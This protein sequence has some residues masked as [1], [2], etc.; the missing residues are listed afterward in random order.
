MAVPAI[1]PFANKYIDLSD[2]ET[3][4]FKALL[5]SM[6][7]FLEVPKRKRVSQERSRGRSLIEPAVFESYKHWDNPWA[8]AN[9]GLREGMKVL[10][11]GSGRGMLQFY[12]SSK[13]M[14]VFSVDISH[15]RSKLFKRIG[16]LLGKIG[17]DYSIDPYIVHR[18]LNRTY[19]TNVTFRHESAA[20]MSF[21]DAYFDR[22][23]CISVIEHM[24]D[25]TIAGSMREMERV[26]KPGGLLLLTFDFHP[27][28]NPS[29]IGFT[30]E[31]FRRKVL[32]ASGLRIVG[33]EPDFRVDGWESYLRSINAF[34]RK[35]NPNTSFGVVL[36][37]D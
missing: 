15:N 6:N 9:A 24:D 4:E 32:A 29:I 16:E 35:N 12:L 3:I 21:P 19:K 28:P 17:I 26:L 8:V 37:R 18:T 11:C 5:D 22:I 36:A 1:F 23:F 34:F 2:F 13:G 33:N 30:V 14:D 31:D 10:D 20:A 25:A 7:A 27:I